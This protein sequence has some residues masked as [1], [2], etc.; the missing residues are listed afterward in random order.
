MH[1][2]IWT[3]VVVLDSYGSIWSRSSVNQEEKAIAQARAEGGVLDE[4]LVEDPA[5][6]PLRVVRLRDPGFLDTIWAFSGP[7]TRLPSPSTAASEPA[8]AL[9]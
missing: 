9:A 3:K 1:P 5:G 6:L 8:P 7:S 2:T 4:W